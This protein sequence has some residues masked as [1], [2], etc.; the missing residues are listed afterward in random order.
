[1]ALLVI[2]NALQ[3]PQ[4]KQCDS[5]GGRSLKAGDRGERTDR[6]MDVIKQHMIG[7]QTMIILEFK[8]QAKLIIEYPV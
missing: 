4:L 2:T 6:Y 7:I 5:G 8:Q 3:L 1:M